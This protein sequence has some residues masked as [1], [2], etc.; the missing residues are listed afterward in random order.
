MGLLMPPRPL[1]SPLNHSTPTRKVCG[2]LL[3]SEVPIYYFRLT[4]MC[5][6][7]TGVPNVSSRPFQEG[8]PTS[9]AP[10]KLSRL[11][12][13]TSQPLPGVPTNPSWLFREGLPKSPGT[14]HFIRKAFRPLPTYQE[15]TPDPNRTSG[16]AYRTL[17]AQQQGLATLPCI[18]GGPPDRSQPCGRDS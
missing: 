4:G 3:V 6:R 7:C 16:R 8:L 2:S 12:G 1:G 17:P 14:Y 10:T 18:P 15:G 5:F 11:S 13:R 9:L